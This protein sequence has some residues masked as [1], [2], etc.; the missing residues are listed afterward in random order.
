M[1]LSLSL[2]QCVIVKHV[3][4][5]CALQPCHILIS[6]KVLTD[7]ESPAMQMCGVHIYYLRLSTFG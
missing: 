2:S 6:N 1:M 4:G 5:G 7:M 3:V